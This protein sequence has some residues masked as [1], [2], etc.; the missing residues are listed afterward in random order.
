MFYQ[1]RIPRNVPVFKI[2]EDD[3]TVFVTKS[4]VDAVITNGLRGAVFHDPSV[5]A[6]M[7]IV[8]GESLNVVPGVPQ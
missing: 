2:P 5:N 8:L 6:L 1:G 3:G 4:F 7:K